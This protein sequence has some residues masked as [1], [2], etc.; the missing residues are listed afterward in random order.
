F[1]VLM[2][3]ATLPEAEQAAQRLIEAIS[4]PMTVSD[5][6]LQIGASIGISVAIPGETSAEEALRNADLAM[7]WAKDNGKA[8]WAVYESRVSVRP[9]QRMPRPAGPHHA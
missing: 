9:P 4:K 8:K 5:V 1:A 7:Y 6:S 3:G 2:E